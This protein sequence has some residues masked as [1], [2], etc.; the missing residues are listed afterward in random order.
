[1]THAPF[2]AEQDG[3]DLRVILVGPSD[4]DRRLRKS[5]AIELVR[6]LSPVASLAELTLPIDGESPRRT[7]I[8]VS[9]RLLS[10]AEAQQFTS[11]ARSLDPE[12][13]IVALATDA[14]A[15]QL[16]DVQELGFDAL[17]SDRADAR[18]LQVLVATPR[19]PQTRRE[20]EHAGDRAESQERALSHASDIDPASMEILLL[21]ALLAGDDATNMSLSLLKQRVGAADLTFAPGAE[22]PKDIGDA[23]VA[24]VSR[25]D[26]TFGWLSCASVSTS[27]LADGARW[28]SYWMALIEQHLQL[29]RAAF[30]DSLTESW[31]RRYFDQYL[32]RALEQARIDRRDLTLLLFDIDDFKTYNDEF[33]HAAGDEILR[34]TVKLLKSVIRPTDLVCR[35]GGDEFVVIFDEPK[36]PRTTTSRHPSSISA[37][38]ARFQRQIVEHRFPKLGPEALGTL[39]I[40]GGMA[41]YPWDGHDA[42]SLLERAD[43]LA[44]QS[45]GAGKNLITLGQGALRAIGRD[46]G[47]EKATGSL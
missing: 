25:N 38:A 42:V 31:N 35:I 7:A 19:Q 40:S 23:P 3:P 26:H 37:I 15:E 33:G 34:E 2:P 5:P 24:E 27:E 18:D 43:Q 22:P 11:A 45:K 39:T 47:D 13:R 32:P 20:P 10:G 14:D 44:L 4:L 1:M 17:I 21:R 46:Q 28:L 6:S 41:T 36:G 30:E 8:I 16:G 9:H 12:V 29:K